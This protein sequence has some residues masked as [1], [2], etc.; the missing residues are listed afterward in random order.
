MKHAAGRAAALTLA[1]AVGLVSAGAAQALTLSSSSFKDGATLPLAYAGDMTGNANCVGKNVSPALSWT[2]TPEGT[3][4]FVLMMVDLE[5]RGGLGVNHFVAYGIPANVS[6]FAEG[7]LSKASPNYVGGKSTQGLATYMGP[8]PPGGT[9][10]HHYTYLLLATDL[11]PKA[12]PPGLT[13]EQLLPMLDGH[14]KGASGISGL[15]AH[16]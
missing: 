16:P 2:G 4:S 5:G 10:A 15:F 14:S 8:C 1:L 12:I 3:K 7:E 9:G 6:G 11:D 13:R